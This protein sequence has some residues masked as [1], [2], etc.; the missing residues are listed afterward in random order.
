MPSKNISHLSSSW[1][2][3]FSQTAELLEL[4][5]TPEWF[6]LEGALETIPDLGQTFLQL[7]VPQRLGFG[8]FSSLCDPLCLACCCRTQA[9]L[10]C[11][12]G[13]SLVLFLKWEFP[14]KMNG[15]VWI[16][17]E[18]EFSQ[19]NEPYSHNFISCRS[20]V[21]ETRGETPLPIREGQVWCVRKMRE[22]QDDFTELT[23]LQPCWIYDY[24]LG[25]FCDLNFIY[26]A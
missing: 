10:L 26:L 13:T 24:E 12:E 16:L 21:P 3:T 22:T 7:S 25:K 19:F 17:M 9:L 6:G 5:W 18:S 4:R 2:I 8:V 1:G 20:S 23:N 15:W 14:V 11:W